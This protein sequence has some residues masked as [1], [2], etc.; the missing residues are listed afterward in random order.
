[1][2]SHAASCARKTSSLAM[3]GACALLLAACDAQVPAGKIT[4]N[5]DSAVENAGRKMAA[6][7][8]AADGSASKAPLA[9]GNAML[10]SRVKAAL[11]ADPDLKALTV[12]VNAADGVVTLFGTADTTARSHRAALVALNVD[13]VRSVK[14]EL[15][16][17]RGS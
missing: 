14:N 13:G 6:A 10:A 3:A 17:V 8:G 12:E 2:N 5:F 7:D 16:I 1:M 15:V 4:K 9:D 11:V